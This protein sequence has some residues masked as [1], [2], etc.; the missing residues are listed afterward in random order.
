M[1]K[2]TTDKPPKESSPPK[3]RKQTTKRSSRKTQRNSRVK[4]ARQVVSSLEGTKSQS[5]KSKRAR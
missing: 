1:N 4:A 3:G 2:K 5:S